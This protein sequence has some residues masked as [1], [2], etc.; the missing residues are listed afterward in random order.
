MER[1]EESLARVRCFAALHMTVAKNDSQDGFSKFH[2]VLPVF[3]V[4]I[5]VGDGHIGDK[6]ND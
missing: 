1:S 4:H 2:R 3:A 5:H 6:D